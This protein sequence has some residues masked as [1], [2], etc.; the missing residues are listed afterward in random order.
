[1]IKN[2]SIRDKKLLL[3]L[4]GLVVFALGYL[5]VFRPQMDK[6]SELQAA[7]LPLKEK[8]AELEDI[9]A[10]Q[11]F[12]VSETEKYEAQVTDYQA[13]FPAAVREED[14]ILL[15]RRMENKLGMWAH[16]LGFQTGQFVASLD[17]SDAGTQD[18]GSEV[19]L[20]EQANEA[21]QEQIDDIEGTA[22]TDSAQTVTVDINPGD[23]ALYRTQN[24]IEFN[25]SYQNLK[26]MVDFLAAE[27]GRTTI[28]SVDISF[29]TS[30]GDLGGTMVV[31]MYAMTG[32]GRTYTKP[33]AS[34]VRFGNRNLF[35]TISGGTTKAASGDAAETAT[36]D[37]EAADTT[38][39]AGTE[40]ATAQNGADSDRAADAEEGTDNATAGMTR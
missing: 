18:G 40:E 13:M 32:T 9:E 20:S 11:S 25:G 2:M 19:T 17:G 8:L 14:A 26:D 21:T 5:L 37:S 39:D 7:N 31:N 38:E 6:A 15:T 4:L 1:M 23:V 10:N 29:S 22:G 28:E 27:S 36:S 30:T 16:T 3:M 34:V 12:Y 35:G 33:D 24:T